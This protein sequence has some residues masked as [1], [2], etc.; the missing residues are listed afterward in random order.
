MSLV[1]AT[2]LA[3]CAQ[4]DELPL[5]STRRLGIP[6]YPESAPRHEATALGAVS[7]CP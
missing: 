2:T 5:V 4:I 1:A 3:M 6:A 7:R